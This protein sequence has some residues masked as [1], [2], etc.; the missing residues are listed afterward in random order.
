MIDTP[1]PVIDDTSVVVR[2]TGMIDSEID[3]ELVGLHLD[4]GN[5]YGFNV[6]ATRIWSII[7]RPTPFSSLCTALSEEFEVDYATCHH[8]TGLLIAELVD[9]RLAEVTPAG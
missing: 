3:G 2:R 8:E 1:A 4:S 9:K 5:C 6:T 7:E